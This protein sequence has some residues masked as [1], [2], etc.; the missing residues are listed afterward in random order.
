ME[1]LSST[2]PT[3]SSL[4]SLENII[5]EVRAFLKGMFFLGKPI[6]NHLFTFQLGLDLNTPR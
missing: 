2:G 4:Y 5:L 3:P 6:C 1:G